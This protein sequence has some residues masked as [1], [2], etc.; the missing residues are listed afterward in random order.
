MSSFFNKNDIITITAD[1]TTY[2]EEIT[3][4]LSTFE[5]SGVPLYVFYN[6]EG[7]PILLPQ[8]LTKQNVMALISEHIDSEE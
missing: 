3:T 1:W 8:V 7:S 5:R 2:N 6:R 4:Y